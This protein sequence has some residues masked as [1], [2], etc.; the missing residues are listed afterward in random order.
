MLYDTATNWSS[1]MVRERVETANLVP[2]R[3]IWMYMRYFFRINGFQNLIGNIVLF[4]PFG[5]LL[6]TTF[7]RKNDVIHSRRTEIWFVLLH[8]FWLSLGIELFQLITCFGE[9]DVD[10]IML[11]CVGVLTGYLVFFH[12]EKFTQKTQAGQKKDTGS[13]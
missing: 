4:M 12:F 5:F 11:N 3:T 9:F 1:S 2:G 6:P 7:L 8:G 10:D 13:R